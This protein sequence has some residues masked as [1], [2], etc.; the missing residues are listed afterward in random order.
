MGLRDTLKPREPRTLSIDIMSETE[1]D[2][3][4]TGIHVDNV[5]GTNPLSLLMQLED[6]NIPSTHRE[7]LKQ[8]TLR[9]KPE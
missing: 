7:A 3:L 8:V 4:S 6:D 5:V 1:V 9:Q 2:A